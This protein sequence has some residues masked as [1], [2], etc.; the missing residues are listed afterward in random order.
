LRR[1]H[2]ALTGFSA[3]LSFLL[4]V[5]FFSIAPLSVRAVTPNDLNTQVVELL[6]NGEDPQEALHLLLE[7]HN[8]LPY[9]KTIRANLAEAYLQVGMD[10][11][12][13]R[14]YDEAAD[15]FH[16]GKSHAGDDPRFWLYQ[17]IA[18]LK[19]G[20]LTAAESEIDVAL[21]MSGN[22]PE[23]KKLLARVYYDSGRLYETLRTL[24]E[25]LDE[26][27]DDEEA[28]TFLEKAR[29]EFDIEERMSTTLASNFT[30]AYDG[31]IH[32]D[33]GN[34]VLSVLEEAYADLGGDLNFYPNV[35]VPV[36]L[37]TRRDFENVTS[38]PDW[39]AGLYDGKIR[40]PLGGVTRMTDRLR[41]LL[42]HEYTH[43]LLRYLAGRT[44]PAWLNEGVAEVAERSQLATPSPVL[45]NALQAD[46]LLDFQLLE[47][48]FSTLP[49]QEVPLAYEQSYSF[50][51][52][53]IETYGWYKLADWLREIGKGAPACE[54]AEKAF[55][56]YM[57]DCNSLRTEWLEELNKE[58]QGP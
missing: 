11:L 38:S 26:D 29:R 17:G 18:F 58:E 30:L 13:E 20:D 56:A 52:F 45:Q 49:Q 16:D 55:E 44:L 24:Q 48:P 51:R 35:Q 21:G 33:L 23:V 37:Y 19:K 43:V 40:I 42:Y 10:A 2:T 32:P 8:A 46:A 53:I 27:P 28:L 57:R 31:E 1:G 47:K 39:A 7:A 50:A 14:R 34:E 6:K 22:D 9:N 25:V 5:A 4:L 3:S 41:A 12:R 36:I 54:A 15:A